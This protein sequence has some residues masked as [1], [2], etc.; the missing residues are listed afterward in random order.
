MQATVGVGGAIVQDEGVTGRA[1][2]GLPLVE[3]VGASLDVSLAVLR[4]RARSAC[5]AAS[6]GRARRDVGAYGNVDLGSLNVDAQF[7]D[8][9]S[10]TSWWA[11]QAELNWLFFC[12]RHSHG[13]WEFRK[14]RDTQKNIYERMLRLTE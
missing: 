13:W 6:E 4:E 9:F 10:D 11:A 8:M 7:F 5:G 3:V 12:A 14:S 1:V 2:L